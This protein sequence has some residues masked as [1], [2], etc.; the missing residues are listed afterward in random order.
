MEADK[1]MP[2]EFYEWLNKCPVQ[3]GSVE[4]NSI[5]YTFICEVSNE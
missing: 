4:E 3:R 2:D 5:E 1:K